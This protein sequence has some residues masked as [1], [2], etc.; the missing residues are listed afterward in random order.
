MLLSRV[1][2]YAVDIGIWYDC[3][4]WTRQSTLV[5]SCSNS[6]ENPRSSSAHKFS[7]WELALYSLAN[8]FSIV[9]KLGYWARDCTMN[10]EFCLRIMFPDLHALLTFRALFE[11]L[12]VIFFRPH[13]C[14]ELDITVGRRQISAVD[15]RVRSFMGAQN[16]Q[17]QRNN[18]KTVGSSSRFLRFWRCFDRNTWTQGHWTVYILSGNC[19][20]PSA[21]VRIEYALQIITCWIHEA[22]HDFR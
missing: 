7:Y 18:R 3:I 16:E 11:T 17:A 13:A 8:F 9:I 22:V 10:L 19:V 14:N 4:M 12:T 21:T 15:E 5:M 2:P 1:R 20:R 6:L